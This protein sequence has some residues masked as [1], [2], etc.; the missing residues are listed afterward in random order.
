[1]QSV[2]NGIDNEGTFT[3]KGNL[4]VKLT[5]HDGIYVHTTTGNFQN[6]NGGLINVGT[7]SG[8]I[9]RIG[10]LNTDGI[11]TNNASTVHIGNTGSVDPD[12]GWGLGN[13][14]SSTF[15]NENGA[16]L[17]LGQS[18][19]SIDRAGIVNTLS[20]NFT[21]DNSTIRIDNTGHIG[22][23]SQRNATFTNNNSGIIDIG[24]NGGNILGEGINVSIGGTINNNSGVINIDNTTQQGIFIE[25]SS[26]TF[27]NNTNGV[28]NIGQNGGTNN[29]GE[30]GI[31]NDANFNN[32]G[33]SI[34]I[35]NVDDDGILNNS[36]GSFC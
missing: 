19:Q 26:G 8:S 6:T 25:G 12:F 32:N 22:I 10:I 24:Q 35:D 11:F 21:N 28:V 4:N 18:G 23:A 27:N 1:M 29:I 17:T 3:N 34:H 20:S 36:G 2:R 15:N 30:Y 9:G 13:Q 33:G 7:S 5:T 31:E 14:E 16:L